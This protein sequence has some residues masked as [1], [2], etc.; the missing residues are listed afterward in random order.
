MSRRW[1]LVSLFVFVVLVFQSHD[2]WAVR[3]L[4]LPLEDGLACDVVLYPPYRT[5]IYLP[6]PAISATAGNTAKYDVK[7]RDKGMRV[8]VQPLGSAPPTNLTIETVSARVT[9]GISMTSSAKEGVSVIRY[10]FPSKWQGDI[11]AFCEIANAT[12]HNALDQI[13]LDARRDEVA[14]APG[15]RLDYQHEGYLLTLETGHLT[16]G[17]TSLSFN[18]VIKNK[19][20]RRYPI[21]GFGMGDGLTLTQYLRDWRVDTQTGELPRWLEPGQTLS[22]QIVAGDPDKLSERFVLQ[23]FTDPGIQPAAFRWNHPPESFPARNARKISLGL[24]AVGGMV[25]L[26][27]MDAEDWTRVLGVGVRASYT[28]FVWL[29]V[30]GIADALSS[31][32][33]ALA[34][35]DTSLSGARVQMSGLLHFGKTI[36]PFVRGGFGVFAGNRSVNGESEFRS[37]FVGVAGV[38]VDVWLASNLV[39]GTSFSYLDGVFNSAE[40][41]AHIGYAWRP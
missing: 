1:T 7:V 34:G 6:E 5:N 40:F 14:V 28:P 4:K 23:L 21:V 31:S 11:P 9:H 41:E 10:V 30:E 25:R 19:G 8:E 29:S 35:T 20:K 39:V 2:A 24:H 13:L 15:V 18:F 16:R 3:S 12:K 27:N 33:A 36:V 22:G 37:G 17:Y 26:D 38:G 32:N